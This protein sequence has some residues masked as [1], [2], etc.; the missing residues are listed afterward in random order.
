MKNSSYC[1]SYEGGNPIVF[2]V[3][4]RNLLLRE[5]PLILSLGKSR[6]R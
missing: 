1:H 4:L 5:S 3:L 2:I 6:T